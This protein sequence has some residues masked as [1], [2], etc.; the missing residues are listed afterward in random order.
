MTIHPMDQAVRRCTDFYA[1]APRGEG[2]F[3]TGAAGHL[4]AGANPAGSPE[5]ELAEPIEAASLS[6]PAREQRVV[7]LK[8]GRRG[9]HSGRLTGVPT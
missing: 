2:C 5:I 4:R 1:I 9:D 7:E 8:S 6:P 3:G